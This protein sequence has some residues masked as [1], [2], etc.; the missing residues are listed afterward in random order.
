MICALSGET[1]QYSD[2][3]VRWQSVILMMG[4]NKYTSITAEKKVYAPKSRRWI[5]IF[6]RIKKEFTRSMQG[7]QS[8]ELH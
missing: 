7:K 4:G 6:H 2:D 3:T 8:N 5:K 1:V